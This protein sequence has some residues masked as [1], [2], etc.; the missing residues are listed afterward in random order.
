MEEEAA[1]FLELEEIQVLG[2][3]LRSYFEEILETIKI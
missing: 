2:S 1:C 3:V